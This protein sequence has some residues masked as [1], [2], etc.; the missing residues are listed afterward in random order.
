MNTKLFR[1]IVGFLLATLLL[2]G[3]LLATSVTVAA[4]RRVQRRV[5]VIRPIDR[6]RDYG[7]FNRYDY[8]SHYTFRNSESAYNEGYKDGRSTGEA[9]GRKDKTYDPERS[10]YFEEAGYGNFAE[11]YREGFTNGLSRWIR[12]ATSWLMR[13]FVLD[14][15]NC[16]TNR[17]E[18]GMD[19]KRM[20]REI[21]AS[22]L[23]ISSRESPFF[24]ARRGSI[25]SFGSRALVPT[26]PKAPWPLRRPKDMHNPVALNQRP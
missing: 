7:R 10:H 9:D 16:S 11:A 26:N 1:R 23:F 19:W 20:P 4:Q 8:Y 15:F 13:T 2:M 3:M 21:A 6:F 14:G 22:S 12:V 5:I 25:Q 24:T 17:A 18:P